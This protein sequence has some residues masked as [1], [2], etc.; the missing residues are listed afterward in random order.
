MQNSL[1]MNI[2]KPLVVLL[3]SLA[4]YRWAYAAQ[5]V[6]VTIGHA[7][8]ISG[9]VAHLGKDSENAA[10]MAVEELNAKG[11]VVNGHKVKFVLAAE[12]DGAD[13]KQGAA[14]AHKLV[15]ARV[16]AVVGHLNSGTSIPAAKIYH[17]A[18]I[19]QISP[20]VTA[21]A[22]SAMGYK[23]TFRVIAD[24]GFTGGKLGSYA[25]NTLNA[26]TIAV[27][28][29]R[30]A[31][32]QGLA[33]QFIKGAKA[34][35][36]HTKFLRRQFTNDK[37]TDFNIILTTI[38]ASK[39]DVIF[40]GGQD[41]VAGPM[42]RQIKSLGINSKFMGGDSICTEKLTELAAD[43]LGNNKVY[44]AIAGGIQ[45]SGQ[46]RMDDFKT[47]YRKRFG[48]DVQLFGP[49]AYDAVMVLAY[50]MQHAESVNPD[51]YLPYLRKIHYKGITGIIAFDDK[52]D[53]K[54]GIISLYTY[55]D[56]RR[57]QISLIQ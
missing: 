21:I 17:M 48:I 47:A 30:T 53:L 46:K 32:G 40:F 29:D 6:T 4:I 13:P 51:V 22:Y 25:V 12:D 39:P 7:A 16:N 11:F 20:S 18:G 2:I 49:Y 5:E 54:N 35:R 33:D 28:D 1:K 36:P 26:R 44:C 15:D 52:G 34:A 56:G 50:A 23:S 9:G 43:G 24:D 10:R 31:Y 55:Q 14:V 38:K 27:I 3:C 8:P 45:K 41:A 19:P 37:A 57:T 42:L